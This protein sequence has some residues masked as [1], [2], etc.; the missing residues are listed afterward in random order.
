MDKIATKLTNYI[1][2]K[3]VISQENYDIYHYGFICF[4]E[5]AVCI[6]TCIIISLFLGMFWKGLFLFTI[7]TPLRS[8]NGGSHMDK[9]YQ[10]FIISCLI[11]LGCLLLVKYFSMPKIISLLAIQLFGVLLLLIG[12]INHPNREVDEEDNV[13]FIHRT[14][15]TVF[16]CILV[17]YGLFLGNKS[18][19]LFLEAIIFTLLL[20]LNVIEKIRKAVTNNSIRC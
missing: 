12:P 4:F 1:L 17:A 8:F 18:N 16:I 5:N 14:R 20:L 10:C 3:G 9:F 2:E 11:F 7:L 6:L 15:I 19:Y 13:V